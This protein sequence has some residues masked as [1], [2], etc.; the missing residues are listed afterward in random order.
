LPG[1]CLQGLELI[2]EKALCLMRAQHDGH[3]GLLRWPL[4]WGLRRC[5]WA[6]RLLAVMLQ[7]L[8]RPRGGTACAGQGG[9]VMQVWRHELES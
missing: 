1:L 7:A 8:A 4:R 3:M 5:G 2:D 6:N 9:G